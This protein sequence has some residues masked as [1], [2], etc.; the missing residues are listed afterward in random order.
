MIFLQEKCTRKDMTTRISIFVEGQTERIFVEKLL[1]EYLSPTKFTR[2]SRIL[3]GDKAISFYVRAIEADAPLYVLICDVMGDGTLTSA[4]LERG[5]NMLRKEG[6]S[7]LLGL[8]DLYN[9]PRA[10]KDRNYKFT[11]ELIKKK[12]FDEKIK[13]VFAIMETEAWFLADHSLFKKIDKLLTPEYIK[14]RLGKDLINYDPELYPKPAN[15]I[16]DIYRLVGRRYK[17]KEDDSYQIAYRINYTFLCVDTPEM[18]KIASF[19]YFLKQLNKAFALA[20]L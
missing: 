6:Y 3:H 8:R 9:I 7:F 14:E 16:D 10:D 15:I 2:E 11:E 4:I 19:H 5:G 20:G 18:K 13:I 12:G 1:D 17:K